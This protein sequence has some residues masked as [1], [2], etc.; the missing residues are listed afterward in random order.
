MTWFIPKL[1]LVALETGTVCARL[2]SPFPFGQKGEW[3]I[4]LNRSSAVAG[5][6]VKGAAARNQ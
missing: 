1:N 4:P 5:L 2:G 3:N 6:E